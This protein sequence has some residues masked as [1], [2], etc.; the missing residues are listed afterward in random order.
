MMSTRIGWNMNNTFLTEM[1]N[2][3]IEQSLQ[4][5]PVAFSR[6]LVLNVPKNVIVT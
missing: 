1:A 6:I 2:M 3:A 5:Y 4:L